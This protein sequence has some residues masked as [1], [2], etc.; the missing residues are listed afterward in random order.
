[1]AK[2]FQ[3]CAANRK[4]ETGKSYT[5]AAVDINGRL[6][7]NLEFNNS[8][9]YGF[10][11]KSFSLKIKFAT[12]VIDP[13]GHKWLVGSFENGDTLFDIKDQVVNGLK[14]DGK[15]KYE[16][17]PNEEKLKQAWVDDGKLCAILCD[18]IPQLCAFVEEAALNRL[19]YEDNNYEV[20]VGTNP[21]IGL[22][23][24]IVEEII[25]AKPDN[26]SPSRKKNPTHKKFLEDNSWFFIAW[27]E[28]TV[29]A[30]LEGT[31]FESE[32]IEELPEGIE[33]EL[34]DEGD[35]VSIKLPWE[36]PQVI[37]QKKKGGG[38]WGNSGQTQKEILA[39]RE[40]YIFNALGV[41]SW[42]E[43]VAGYGSTICPIK[44]EWVTSVANGSQWHNRFYNQ[45]I[46][47]TQYQ[48]ITSVEQ[49][50]NG[51]VEH[52]EEIE[53]QPNKSKRGRKKKE[54][55]ASVEEAEEEYSENEDSES[56]GENYAQLIVKLKEQEYLIPKE[57]DKVALDEKGETWCRLFYQ[58]MS[59]GL[60]T[61]KGTIDFK[62]RQ[63]T[64]FMKSNFG[65]FPQAMTESDLKK[66]LASPLFVA[67]SD[68]VEAL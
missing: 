51:H 8:G 30:C 7:A 3:I 59:G 43:A 46:D 32:S 57:L 20:F 42:D 34:D 26:P 19:V 21:D 13:S 23:K 44:A 1:M 28:P 60:I 55:I 66:V 25:E 5:N 38:S 48:M 11:D 63:S 54:E 45:A 12:G 40:Q 52:K 36:A 24:E 64:S 62:A 18:P 35:L 67:K 53:E 61:P 68:E 58:L 33:I 15:P 65:K 49:N 9:D 10:K 27:D 14:P 17:S 6:W 22:M 47:S 56:E 2:P 16:A 4:K 50:G 31:P 37:E 41:K 29:L 39:E